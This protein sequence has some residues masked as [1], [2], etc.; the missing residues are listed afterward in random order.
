MATGR[1]VESE[2]SKKLRAGETIEMWPSIRGAKNWPHAAFNPNTGLLYAN[3]NHGYS[4][5]RFT[6]AI[7]RTSRARATR[8]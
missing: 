2:E 1:P 5:Y 8:A 7:R 3:T 4:T 6:A